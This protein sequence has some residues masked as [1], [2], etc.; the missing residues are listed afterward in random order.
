LRTLNGIAVRA[1]QL[2]DFL[3]KTLLFIAQ[4]KVFIY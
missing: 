1:A 2:Q 3:I 4:I